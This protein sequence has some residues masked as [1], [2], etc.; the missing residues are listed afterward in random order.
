MAVVVPIENPADCEVLLVFCRP[1]R[2]Q[3]ILPK[4]QAFAWNCSVATQ[5]TVAYCPTAM[6]R[7]QFYSDIF[8]HPP[9]SPDLA[10]SDFFLFPKMKEHLAGK[11]F[12]NDEDLKNTVGGH[13][14]RQVYTQTV[15]K[16]RQ[17]LKCQ[18]RLSEKLDKGMCHNVYTQFLYY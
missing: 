4:R 6:L 2:S 7:E 11:R 14:V 12:V 3:V 8:E 13:M 1:M 15:A 9:Y 17:V 18:R 10:P 5:C 16:V